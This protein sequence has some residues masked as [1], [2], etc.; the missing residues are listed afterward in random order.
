LFGFLARPDSNFDLF[1]YAN[2]VTG[3]ESRALI[4][5][6][7]AIVNS[8]IMIRVSSLYFAILAIAQYTHFFIG[9]RLPALVG[10]DVAY[11]DGPNSF[12][13]KKSWLLMRGI[14]QTAFMVLA[15][16]TSVG[17]LVLMSRAFSISVLVASAYA[18]AV[19]FSVVAVLSAIYVPLAGRK[20]QEPVERG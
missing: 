8:T 6:S 5:C 2:E 17:I 3:S 9:R 19:S 10:G 4:W 20:F 11:W 16:S 12:G 18:I 7:I 13:L 14:S 1:S 15:S